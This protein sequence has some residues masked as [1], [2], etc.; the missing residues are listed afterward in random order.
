MIAR[1]LLISS[2]A[3]AFASPAI[4]GDGDVI[5]APDLSQA[6]ARA[7]GGDKIRVVTLDESVEGKY[8]GFSGGVLRLESKGNVME[9][10]AESVRAMSKQHR[11]GGKGFLVGALCGFGMGVA[12]GAAADESGESAVFGGITLGLLGGA[13]GWLIG[14][15][16]T[17]WEPLYP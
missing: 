10:P 15:V 6:L 5:A 16:D 3:A 11:H 2:L 17:S 4:A 7:S 8:R 9:F 14:H 1:L 13:V 12:L